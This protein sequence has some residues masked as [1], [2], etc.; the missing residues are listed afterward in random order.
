MKTLLSVIFDCL[1]CFP[2][3]NYQ[4]RTAYLEIDL[5]R[6]ALG[7]FREG[8]GVNLRLF[9]SFL[10]IGVV[11]SFHG[12]L[13]SLTKRLAQRNMTILLGARSTARTRRM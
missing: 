9:Y 2:P 4:K 8:Y 7:N 6:D 11:V 3:L 12:V 1:H 13:T 10:A 5:L